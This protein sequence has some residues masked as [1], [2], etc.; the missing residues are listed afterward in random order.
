[1]PRHRRRTPPSAASFAG[2]ITTLKVKVVPPPRRCVTVTS[3]PMARASCLTD[4]NPS[5]APPKRDAMETLACENGRNRRL[6]SLSVRPIPLS[7][8]SN[9]TATLPFGL[10]SGV[11]S[12]GDAALFGEFHGI[13]DQ[14]LH[15]GA[16]ADGIADRKRRELFGN[17]DRRLQALGRRAAGQRIAGIAG[18]RAQVEEV[19]PHLEPGTAAARRIDE[20][21]RKARQMFRA[22]LDGVDP[23]PF[24]LVEIGGREQIADRQNACERRADLVRKGR[25]RGLD[26]AGAGGGGFAG[27]RA[28]LPRRWIR[29]FS[30][31]ASLLAVWCAVSAASPPWSPFL[32]RQQHDTRRRPMSRRRFQQPPVVLR[33]SSGKPTRRRISAGVTP[34]PRNSRKAVACVDFESLCPDASSM[35]R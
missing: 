10:R 3:P 8:T 27:T 9:A 24:A 35:S 4:D 20:Q 32:C 13:V 6:I 18:E 23:A 25:Q 2:A 5:P 17:N 26:H 22:R 28:R 16:Q 21:R 33:E 34:C 7:E 11:T 12:Q 19:L 1:M 15:R 14:V 30:L 29:A 31:A